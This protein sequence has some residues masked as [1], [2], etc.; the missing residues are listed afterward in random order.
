MMGKVFRKTCIRAAVLS[1]MLW[2]SLGVAGS[3]LGAEE[4]LDLNQASVAEL[5]SLPGIGLVRAQAIVAR[6]SEM[7]FGRVEELLDVPGIGD[8]V[9]AGL[10]SRVRIVPVNPPPSR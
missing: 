8:A 3:A 9:F 7:R 1:A 2:G 6:R 10:Q 4:V 5:S